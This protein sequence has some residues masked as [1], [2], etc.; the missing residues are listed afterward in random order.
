[1]LHLARPTEV[2]FRLPGVDDDTN[3]LLGHL[4][5]KLDAKQPRNHLRASYYDGKRAIQQIGSLIPP[6]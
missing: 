2:K 1:M 6:Q 5:E 4:L 3:D